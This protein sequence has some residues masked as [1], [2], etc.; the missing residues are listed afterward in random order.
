METSHI[1]R[2]ASEEI[3]DLLEQIEEDLSIYLLHPNQLLIELICSD[4]EQLEQSFDLFGEIELNSLIR[5]LNDYFYV[6]SHSNDVFNSKDYELCV[7]E[8]KYLEK[9]LMNFRESY[10]FNVN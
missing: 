7:K 2:I 6:M 4:L 9:S 5:E 10:V 1:N 3:G 8:I